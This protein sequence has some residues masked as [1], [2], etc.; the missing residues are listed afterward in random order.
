[1]LSMFRGIGKVFAALAV[2]VSIVANVIAFQRSCEPRS[3]REC[4]ADWIDWALAKEDA[5]VLAARQKKIQ[6]AEEERIKTLNIEKQRKAAEATLRQ[7]EADRAREAEVLR[8]KFEEEKQRADAARVAR[9]RAHAEERRQADLRAAGKLRE[10]QRLEEE[11]V[12]AERREHADREARERQERAERDHAE[13]KRAAELKHQAHLESIRCR[14]PGDGQHRCCPYGQTPELYQ[15][16]GSG[17]SF[18]SR[19][20][21][22]SSR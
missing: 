18:H 19:C 5:N 1:M 22:V 10:E 6:E 14:N 11:R 15:V 3:V 8:K 2:V 16:P 20:R 4:A 17:V 12:R 21:T 9:E 13:R 7:E